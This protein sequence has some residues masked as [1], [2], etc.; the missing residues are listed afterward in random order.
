MGAILISLE[1]GRELAGYLF[2]GGHTSASEPW[3]ADDI[4]NA[5]SL[6]GLRLEHAGNEVFELF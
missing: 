6:A 4:S 3:V 5:E 2:A 1:A